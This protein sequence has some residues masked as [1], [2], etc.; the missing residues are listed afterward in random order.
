MKTKLLCTLTILMLFPLACKK[1]EAG[2][3]ADPGT[4]TDMTADMVPGDDKGAANNQAAT[5]NQ[6][7]ANNQAGTDKAPAKGGTA[8]SIPE[9]YRILADTTFPK[10]CALTVAENL[11][12]NEGATLT[13]EPGV[14]LSFRVDRGLHVHN[15]KLVAKGTPEEPV[16]LTSANSTPSAG[17][18]NGIIFVDEH[19]TGQ[20]LDHVILEYAG[21]DN[22]VGQNGAIVVHASQG[23]KRISI[24]NC[25]LRHNANQGII[26]LHEKG[27]FARIENCVF[28]KNGG[29]A[30]NLL[31][32]HV[33]EIA[34]N[35]KIDEKI[36]IRGPISRS[37]T[38]P[39]L[40]VPFYVH[41]NI[42]IGNDEN[43]SILT[44]PEGTVMRF[45][46]DTGLYVGSSGSGGLVAK[47]V[48]FT[49]HS[50]TPNPGDWTGIY[51][52]EK[53]TGTELAECVLE[54]AG[55]DGPLGK[56]ALIVQ[57]ENTIPRKAKISKLHIRNA[58]KAWQ[59][60]AGDC[61][62]LAKAEHGNQMDEKPFVCPKEEE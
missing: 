15:G 20:V 61:A 4:T 37:V 46:A 42:D 18:W 35:N 6:A 10:G 29:T 53:T 47:K 17:D 48:T 41:E 43:S 54:H 30:M 39:K 1:K 44:L 22:Y 33:G 56:G 51:L 38:F 26:N 21:H 59:G 24:T 52:W 57:S 11:E 9:D 23:D 3:K 16:I 40:P 58:D 12:I 62:E 50:T 27:G 2:K 32:Q 28:E 5:N 19:L 60:P 49:S 14:K 13:L 34:E 55:K 25:I 8:C 31:A 7:A 36:T 45:R